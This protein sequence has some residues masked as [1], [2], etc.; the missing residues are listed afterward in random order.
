MVAVQQLQPLT[1]Q[2]PEGDL[3]GIGARVGRQYQAV[4]GAKAGRQYQ[5]P[6]QVGSSRQAVQ[7]PGQVGC[8]GQVCRGVQT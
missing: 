4:S 6:G 7:V 8:H 5:V 1:A 2:V 3:H